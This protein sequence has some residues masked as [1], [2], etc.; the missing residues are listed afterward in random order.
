MLGSLPL[1]AVLPRRG[2][3]ITLRAVFCET[4]SGLTVIGTWN[5]SSMMFESQISPVRDSF[6][7]VFA[8]PSPKR[9]PPG[10]PPSQ[11]SLAVELIDGSL[12]ASGEQR[13]QRWREHFADQ[14]S[15]LAVTAD[16]CTLHVARIDAG[17]AGNRQVSFDPSILPDLLSVEADILGLRRGKAAGPDG[18]TGELLRVCPGQAARHFLGLHLK[19][20]LA[21]REPVE[22]KGG[23]LMTLAKQTA[24]V[25]Q[26][27]KH[28]SILLSSVPGKIFHRGIRTRLTPAL[29]AV[30]PDLH[31]GVRGHVGVDTISLAVKC[32]QSHVHHQGELPAL[33]FYDVRAAYY[34]VLRE[35]LTGDALDDRVV[36]SLFNRLGVPPSAYPELRKA[37]ESIASLADCC[38]SE[39]SVALATLGFLE[40]PFWEADLGSSILELAASF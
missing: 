4:P 9:L 6:T 40:A 20:T 17:R 24:T 21:L 2:R 16:E 11:L 15:G 34:Q 19:S 1:T 32:F 14:E 12:A 31:G 5:R 37:L 8:K 35:T 30:C 13:A 33:V 39:H 36:L 27:D 38:D 29:L 18:N 22:Y 3:P 28:R 10:A 26:C 7:S 23:A 25:F